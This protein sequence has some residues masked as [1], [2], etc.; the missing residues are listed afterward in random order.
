MGRELANL[1][2]ILGLP[3]L[4]PR[5]YATL[6][7]PTS[8]SKIAELC[9]CGRGAVAGWENGRSH[10]TPHRLWTLWLH[11]LEWTAK[12]KLNHIAV[13]S[14]QWPRAIAHAP[15]F[16]KEMTQQLPAQR[17]TARGRSGGAATTEPEG[18]RGA[19]VAPGGVEESTAP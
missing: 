5:L 10:P 13:L 11:F 15:R 12:G 6:R 9:D 18:G 4:S 19:E 7:G 8:R 17:L 16:T 1:R 14:G 2:K 3:R